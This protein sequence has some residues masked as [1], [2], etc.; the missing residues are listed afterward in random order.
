[1]SRVVDAAAS[2]CGEVAGKVVDFATT[3][4]WHHSRVTHFQYKRKNQRTKEPTPP[5]NQAP[6]NP[7]KI[8]IAY[9]AHPLPP[10]ELL[11]SDQCFFL[12]PNFRKMANVFQK[13]PKQQKI[14]WFL[15]IVFRH[16]P[17]EIKLN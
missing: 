16:F 4:T 13:M 8:Y 11:K 10:P 7:K 6:T 14:M 1:M 12:V 9:E 15:G 2:G 17:N 3:R 5:K